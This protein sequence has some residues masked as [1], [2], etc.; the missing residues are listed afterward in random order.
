MIRYEAYIEKDW[1]NLGLANLLLVRTREDGTADLAGFLVD[2]FCLGVKDAWLYDRML[3][4][5]IEEYLKERVPEDLRERLH[6]ACAKKLIEGAVAYAEGLGFAPHRDYRK[7]RKVLSGIEASACPREFSFGRD[8]RPCYIRGP[9]DDEARVNRICGILE[10]RFGIEG[11]DYE[12]PGEQEADDLGVRDELMQFLDDEAEDVPRFYEFSGL[13]TAML[14][15]PGNPSP[16]LLFPVL[17]PEDRPA[18]HGRDDFGHFTGNLQ[19]Y[20]NRINDLV[21]E[22][23]ETRNAAGL[24]IVDLYEEDFSEGPEGGL[25]MAAASFDWARGFRLTTELWPELWGDAL[26]RPDLAPHWEVI[27]WWAGLT[28]PGNRDRIADAAEADEPRTLNASVV[29]LARALRPTLTGQR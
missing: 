4:D 6:P 24:Q 17:W 10:T 16:N 7:A 26:Q 9:E 29:A 1:E 28:A 3:A 23:V 2:V 11:F 27:G 13:V 18:A 25:A 21:L 22:I 19:S 12:D 5:E 14:I 8:G 15:A 20:W